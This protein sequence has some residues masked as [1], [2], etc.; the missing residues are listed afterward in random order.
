MASCDIPLLERQKEWLAGPLVQVLWA[1]AERKLGQRV[2]ER[3]GQAV[4]Q[5][6]KECRRG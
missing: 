2:W 5:G 6:R 4:R 1:Q 3:V